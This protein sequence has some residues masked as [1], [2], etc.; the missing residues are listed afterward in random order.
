M[1]CNSLIR[2]SYWERQEQEGIWC[3]RYL[4]VEKVMQSKIMSVWRLLKLGIWA[5]TL[6]GGQPRRWLHSQPL[7]K[8][9]DRVKSRENH[10]SSVG[11]IGK[12]SIGLVSKWP[13]DRGMINNCHDASWQI[14]TECGA[15]GWDEELC[16]Y[17]KG[18]LGENMIGNAS[19]G[20]GSG[21]C[22]QSEMDVN[23]IVLCS[24]QTT[25]CIK[26]AFKFI[27]HII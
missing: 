4:L 10:S 11:L 20:P 27:F 24:F 12:G 23:N 1:P 8:D 21:R 19:Y 7:H 26:K 5:N 15:R 6:P 22:R 16:M 14:W 17:K 3:V 13:K 25:R 2:R 18:C 9:R